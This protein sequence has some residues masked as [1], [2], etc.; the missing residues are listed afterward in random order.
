[1]SNAG[2]ET[3]G[4]AP[5]PAT[6]GERRHPHERAISGGPSREMEDESAKAFRSPRVA[7]ST[8][9]RECNSRGEVEGDARSSGVPK[10][11]IECNKPR[12]QGERVQANGFLH[13]SS[14][15]VEAFGQRRHAP[16]DS[17]VEVARKR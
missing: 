17:E 5:R 4:K 1:M 7:S 16:R 2:E 14:T 9:L 13:P 15:V 3:I 12:E 10:D 11:V 8:P 6:D